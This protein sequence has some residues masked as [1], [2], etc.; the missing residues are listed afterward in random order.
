MSENLGPLV[1]SGFYNCQNDN[2]Q[3]NNGDIFFIVLL[4]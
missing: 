4:K 1:Y 3:M 2:F